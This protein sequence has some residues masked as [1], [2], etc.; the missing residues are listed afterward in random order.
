[1][2]LK[3]KKKPRMQIAY[4][5]FIYQQVAKMMFQLIW[6]LYQKEKRLDTQLRIKALGGVTPLTI[7]FINTTALSES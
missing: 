2:F 1:M 6:Q 4:G 3:A 5:V 7:F